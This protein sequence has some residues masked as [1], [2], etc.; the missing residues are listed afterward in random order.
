[1]S[2]QELMETKLTDLLLFLGC[3]RFPE[4]LQHLSEHQIL[5]S[6]CLVVFLTLTLKLL[7]QTSFSVAPKLQVFARSSEKCENFRNTST[8]CLSVSLPHPEIDN[9]ML[10][11]KLEFRFLFSNFLVKVLT[12]M[13]NNI[14]FDLNI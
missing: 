9:S 13:S 10:N 3:A 1:M 6:L 2:K 14:V 8:P 7:I 5:W 4:I 11:F 12:N